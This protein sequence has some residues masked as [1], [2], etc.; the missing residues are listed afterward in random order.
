M[1]RRGV[2]YDVGRVMMGQNWRPVFDRNEVGRELEIIAD[3]LHATAVRICGQD[4][5]RL[6]AA[7]EEALERGLE[8]WLSPELWDRGPDE[9]LAYIAEAAGRAE[10]LLQRRPGQL[11]LS[12]GSELTLF[13]QGIVEGKTVFDR[14]NNPSFWEHVR[15]GAHNAPLN[16]FL[17]K[18]NDAVRQAFH[19]SVTYASVP[20]EPVNWDLFDIVSVDLYRDV[21]IK[22]RFTDLLQRYFTH[23]RPVVITETGC[24]TYRGAAEAGGMGWA[25]VGLDIAQLG[26]R[27]PELNGDYIRDEAEQARELTELLTIFDQA[28]VDGTFL[29][30]FVAPLSP[31]SDDPRHDLDMASYSLVRSYGNRLGDLAT[32][33]PNTFWDTNRSGATYPEMPWEPKEAFQAVAGFYADQQRHA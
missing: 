16:E 31:Y 1:N 9:T 29:M 30:T 7:S 28:G 5:D 33:F 32:R 15:S 4:L 25:I 24:C 12:V 3:D 20:L 2:C 23:D 26:T 6:A 13:M 8:V 17:A 18:A 27:P 11:V 14:M 10:D 21:R 22:D 19:G